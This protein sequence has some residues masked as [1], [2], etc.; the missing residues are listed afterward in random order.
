MTP[1]PQDDSLGVKTSYCLDP[2]CQAVKEWLD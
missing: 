2:D 1:L